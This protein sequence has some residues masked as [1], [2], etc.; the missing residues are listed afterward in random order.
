MAVLLAV[1]ESLLTCK[2]PSK[3]KAKEIVQKLIESFENDF[4]FD[5]S[6]ALVQNFLEE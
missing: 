6:N 3:K 1:N 4:E 5:A 2:V